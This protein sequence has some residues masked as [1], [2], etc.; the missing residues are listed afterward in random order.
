MQWYG[1]VFF[2]CSFLLG[3]LTIIK[4]NQE[5]VQYLRTRFF[6]GE[7]EYLSQVQWPRKL[8]PIVCPKKIDNL[9]FSLSFGVLTI[10]YRRAHIETA[11]QKEWSDNL[12][13][14]MTWAQRIQDSKYPF[15]N[16]NRLRLFTDED[17]G[18]VIQSLEDPNISTAEINVVLHP[19]ETSP[20]LD[21]IVLQSAGALDW[22]EFVLDFS[23]DTGEEEVENERKVLNAIRREIFNSPASLP[24]VI[25]IALEGTSRPMMKEY[26]SDLELFLRSMREGGSHNSSHRAFIMEGYHSA[27]FGTTVHNLTPLFTGLPVANPMGDA[28]EESL[29]KVC[30]DRVLSATREKFYWSIYSEVGYRTF[31]GMTGEHYWGCWGGKKPN[32]SCRDWSKEENRFLAN[33]KKAAA[34]KSKEF[35]IFI[36]SELCKM[37]GGLWQGASARLKGCGDC[38]CCSH[39]GL[40]NAKP[41]LWRCAEHEMARGEDQSKDQLAKNCHDIGGVIPDED[42][43]MDFHG[44]SCSCCRKTGEYFGER[45]VFTFNEA[46]SIS[47]G[48]GGSLNVAK[49]WNK[50]A[51]CAGSRLLHEAY[52]DELLRS[53]DR[54]V[55]PLFS[56]IHLHEPH[57]HREYLSVVAESL[58]RYIDRIMETE[59]NSIIILAG[60]HGP[61]AAF[62]QRMPFLSI[63]MPNKLLNHPNAKTHNISEN[64][65]ANEQR[66]VT[67]FDIYL[68]FGHILSLFGN[69]SK[70]NACFGEAQAS[71]PEA[72]LRVVDGTDP[73]QGYLYNTEDHQARSLFQSIPANRSCNMAGIE[74]FHCGEGNWISQLGSSKTTGLSDLPNRSLGIINSFLRSKA[75]EFENYPCKILKLGKVLSLDLKD[76]FPLSEP[77]K[78]HLRYVRT[79]F[80]T[81]DEGLGSVVYY[82]MFSYNVISPMKNFRVLYVTQKT[83]Y[84]R[85]GKCRH[86]STA[87]LFCVCN[88]S[89]TPA[90]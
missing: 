82:M 24:S 47:K 20:G 49:H 16:E 22:E 59:P 10:R 31:S 51:Q 65:R 6:P 80:S 21:I 46:S 69:G 43:K 84:N 11:S 45:G 52:M 44:C 27:T 18:V 7:T 63:L 78:K 41:K 25:F 30:T 87:G 89:D 35:P 73:F 74:D 9:D 86:T 75:V 23:R 50:T 39:I 61:P 37:V 77:S 5:G 13:R 85:Y 42:N 64:L 62:D 19:P 28:L 76:E 48:L 90:I 83:M 66:L 53:I 4:G 2:S 55:A 68:T 3:L 79:V 32:Y 72:M 60:D 56:Y 17:F 34:N 88:A 12:L 81:L 1:T 38:Y 8:D 36:E 40:W 67:P 54:K 15:E 14:D 26:G 70:V 57:D 71:Y 29:Q 58:P 33:M